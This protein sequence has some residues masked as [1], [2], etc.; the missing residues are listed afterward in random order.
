[1]ASAGRILIMPKGNWDANTEYEMLD[2]VFHNGTSWLAKKNVVG[3]EPSEDNEEHWMKMCEADLTSCLKLSGGILSGD[4]RLEKGLPRIQL[5]NL[6]TTRTL[7]IES[8]E[9]GISSFGNYLSDS[10]QTNLQLRKS[11]E[12]L[13]ELLR[14]AVDG[15]NSYRL[16]GEHNVPLLK[17]AIFKSKVY[18]GTTDSNGFLKPEDLTVDTTD[19]IFCRLASGTGFCTQFNDTNAH[20]SYK[21][22]NWDRT[23]VAN[24]SVTIKVVYLVI[25]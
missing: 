4:L 8:G 25:L 7:T 5:K 21:I 11:S 1:M 10:D 16:F 6:G 17:E 14:L 9:T 13:S 22:E 12:G 15:K 2:L 24:K 3:I 20:W 23:P 18:N 19:V